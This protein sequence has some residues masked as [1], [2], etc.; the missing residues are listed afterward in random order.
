MVLEEKRLFPLKGCTWFRFLKITLQT[1]F[2]SFFMSLFKKAYARRYTAEFK[3][4]IGI[5]YSVSLQLF[6]KSAIDMAEQRN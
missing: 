1:R 3:T 6:A 2:D 4:K 5:L